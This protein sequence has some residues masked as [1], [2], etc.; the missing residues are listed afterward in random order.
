MFFSSSTTTLATAAAVL[1]I[2]TRTIVMVCVRGW[3]RRQVRTIIASDRM[4]GATSIF[5]SLKT[6]QLLLKISNNNYY[7]L[8]L[9][10]FLIIN[11][12]FHC[13][14]LSRPAAIS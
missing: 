7:N 3:W 11:K 4:A 1:A 2:V 8:C 10:H 6:K 14:L 12:S 9:N 5:G 13:K